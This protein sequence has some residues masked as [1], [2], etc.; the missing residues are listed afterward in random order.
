[1]WEAADR[2]D[3]S[4]RVVVFDVDVLDSA[5]LSSWVLKHCVSVGNVTMRDLSGDMDVGFWKA[6]AL[7][8]SRVSDSARSVCRCRLLHLDES[9]L[10]MMM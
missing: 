5:S 3:G 9:I 4:T 1:M 8:P 7:L 2:L 6:E 10:V